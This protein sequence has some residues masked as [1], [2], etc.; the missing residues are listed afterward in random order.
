MHTVPV[1]VLLC[2]SGRS[3]RPWLWVQSY[4]YRLLLLVLALQLVSAVLL[5]SPK[6]PAAHDPTYRNGN[7]KHGCEESTENTRSSTTRL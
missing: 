1:L 5:L 3:L 4:R 6:R 7:L 2:Q